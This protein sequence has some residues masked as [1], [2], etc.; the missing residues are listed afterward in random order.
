MRS[1]MSTGTP[2]RSTT[3]PSV[4]PYVTYLWRNSVNIDRITTVVSSVTRAKNTEKTDE[5]DRIE[6]AGSRDRP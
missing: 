3:S 1:I 5:P 4:I 2:Y 6:Q